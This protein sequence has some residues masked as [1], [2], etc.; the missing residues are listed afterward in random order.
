MDL[1]E[2]PVGNGQEVY[3]SPEWLSASDEDLLPMPDEAET[4]GKKERR[5]VVDYLTALGYVVITDSSKVSED[6][7]FFSPC[8]DMHIN[9]TV[10][11]YVEKKTTKI[12]KSLEPTNV[13]EPLTLKFEEDHFPDNIPPLPFVLKNEIAQGGTDKVLIKTPK[14]LEI[15]KKF[16]EEIYDYSFREAV[17]ESR[18]QQPEI[19]F[20]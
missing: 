18:A 10:D 8:R 7:F 1:L 9:A 3:I 2:V 19:E 6:T 4:P 14:Q 5:A 15:F 20:Y 16:Y 17:E 12:H 11:E 13:H